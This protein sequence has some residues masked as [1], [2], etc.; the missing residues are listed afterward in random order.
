MEMSA[1]QMGYLQVDIIKGGDKIAKK[2]LK[3]GVADR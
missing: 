3:V 2:Q 1:N